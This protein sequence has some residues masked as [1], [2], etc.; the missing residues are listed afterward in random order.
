MNKSFL[1]YDILFEIEYNI[2]LCLN[3]VKN[4]HV[5]S[6]MKIVAMMKNS[7]NIYLNLITNEW[8][9]VGIKLYC[10]ITYDSFRFPLSVLSL[11]SF[12]LSSFHY[13]VSESPSRSSVLCMYLRNPK[14]NENDFSTTHSPCFVE[15]GVIG[16]WLPFCLSDYYLT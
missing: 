5:G 9:L 13:L 11:W 14:N 10:Y 6:Y 4:Q 12:Y 2:H 8:F 16:C 1:I 15:K 7:F 3:I